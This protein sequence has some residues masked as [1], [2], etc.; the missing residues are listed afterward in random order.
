[1]TTDRVQK[2]KSNQEEHQKE[3]TQ[4]GLHTIFIYF[5]SQLNETQGN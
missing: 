5:F 3:K 2:E 4:F 1:L